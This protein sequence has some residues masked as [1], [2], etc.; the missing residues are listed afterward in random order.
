MSLGLRGGQRASR[1]AGPK[2]LGFFTD[3]HQAKKSGAPHP[4]AVTQR[5]NRTRM[6]PMA[7]TLP[8]RLTE[9]K[10]GL[11]RLLDWSPALS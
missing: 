6:L 8:P 11:K 2:H 7:S 10:R 5:G 1:N 3:A 9:L 4:K